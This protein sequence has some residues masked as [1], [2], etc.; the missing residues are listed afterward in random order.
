MPKLDARCAGVFWGEGINGGGING[1]GYQWGRGAAAGNWL[2]QKNKKRY[3]FSP[4]FSFCL[5][6]QLFKI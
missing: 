1:G 5:R 2:R 6:L 4:H 3:W